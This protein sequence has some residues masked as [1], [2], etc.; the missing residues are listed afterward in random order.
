MSEQL[1]IDQAAQ[2]IDA[3]LTVVRNPALTRQEHDLLR[4]SLQMLY[5]KAKDAEEV[6]AA[7]NVIPMPMKED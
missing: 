7:P 1:T 3:V 4:M 2:N 6:N 5:G